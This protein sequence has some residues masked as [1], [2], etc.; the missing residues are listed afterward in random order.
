MH[1]PFLKWLGGKIRLISNIKKLLPSGKRLVEPFVGSG[2]IFLNTEYNEYLLADSNN[3][4]ISL[5][6]KL[7]KEGR[8]FI[9]IS[10]SYFISKNN[11]EEEYLRL[12]EEFNHTKNPAIFVYLNR[13]CFNGLCRYNSDGEFNTPFGE[14]KDPVHFPIHEMILFAEK[15][16][17]KKVQFI[18][19]DFRETFKQIKSGDI[20]YCDPPYIPLSETSNFT[21]Y[22]ADGFSE[23]DHKDLIDLV[24]QSSVPTLISNHDTEKVKKLYNRSTYIKTIYAGRFVGGDRKSVKE[25]LA[26]FNQNYK[27][28][29]LWTT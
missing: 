13:H 5:F 15:C 16:R 17:E 20:V 11:K 19:S 6:I 23:K 29:T 1:K 7:Y 26:L 3:D 2:A 24:M 8:K 12:R 18:H 25:I 9:D 10:K 27:E 22:D 4:L 21:S 28:E 14:Y